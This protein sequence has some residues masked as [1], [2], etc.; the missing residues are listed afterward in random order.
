MQ[1]LYSKWLELDL[2][3]RHRIAQEFGIVKRN[4]TH[5]QDNVVVSDGYLIKEVE[6]ALNLDA[7]QRVLNTSETDMAIL[8]DILVNSTPV[9]KSETAPLQVSSED[10]EPKIEEVNTIEDKPKKHGK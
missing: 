7:M 5:V 3:T 1:F 2:P 8:W 10:V 6:Q 9:S 4:S